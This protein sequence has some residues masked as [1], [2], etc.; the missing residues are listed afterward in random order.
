MALTSNS[1][2]EPF[3]MSHISF[4]LI[5]PDCSASIQ[6]CNGKDW[7]GGTHP[8]AGSIEHI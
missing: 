6:S 3:S 1:N 5:F 8:N 7:P 4:S 2:G